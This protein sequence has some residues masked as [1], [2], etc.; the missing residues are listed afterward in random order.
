MADPRRLK[1]FIQRYGLTY[2]V[3]LVGETKELNAKL[4]QAVGLNAWPTTFFLG[5]DG[6]VRATHVGF[7]S[8]GSGARD[9]ETRR[10]VEHTVETLLAEK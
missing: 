7:T 9:V 8:P 10:E 1:A 2:T 4:P 5:R 6:R 3:L